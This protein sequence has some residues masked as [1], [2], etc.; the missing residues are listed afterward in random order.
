M[1][2]LKQTK[3][4]ILSIK[5]TQK[6][7]RAMKLVASAKYARAN[8]NMMNAKPYIKSFAET[9][10]TILC[11]GNLDSKFLSDK[12]NED[13]KTLLVVLSSDRGLCGSLNSSLFKFVE[14]KIKEE[15]SKTN[16]Q[17]ELWGKRSLFFGNSRSE[18]ITFTQEKVLDKPS[19]EFIQ[20]NPTDSTKNISPTSSVDEN[21]NLVELVPLS[22]STRDQDVSTGTG[23]KDHESG[24]THCSG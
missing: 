8:I 6:I 3:R 21:G 11:Q 20:K 23:T 24:S 1:A 19:Y 14:N 16:F 18:E 13:K 22:V 7:T 4:R 17:L 5:N 10:Q 12:K 15:K 2:S 9:L